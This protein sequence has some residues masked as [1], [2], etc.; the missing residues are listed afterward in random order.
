MKKAMAIAIFLGAAGLA[1]AALAEDIPPPPSGPYAASQQPADA[2]PADAPRAQADNPNWGPPPPPPPPYGYGYPAPQ[3]PAANNGDARTASGQPAAP[4]GWAPP[5]PPPYGYYDGDRAY[6]R[7][8]GYGRGAG[9]G[10]M[11]GNFSFGG[12]A[13]TD[14]NGRSDDNWNG[15]NRGRR[16]GWGPG[17]W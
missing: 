10:H 12:G 1:G 15:Y 6:G 16:G 2:G 17:W 11:N 9:R 3:Q 8:Y 5:P 4:Q 7:G 14:V 13:D